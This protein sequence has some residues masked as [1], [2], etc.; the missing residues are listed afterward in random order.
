MYHLIRS[1]K[2]LDQFMKGM[3]HRHLP[4]PAMLITNQQDMMYVW[5]HTII[6]GFTYHS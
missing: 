6:S 5:T 1:G 3:F 4:S 2:P